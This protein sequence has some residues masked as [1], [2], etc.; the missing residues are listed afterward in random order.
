MVMG[1]RH[2]EFPI[3]GLQFHPESI[4]TPE[5]ELLIKNFMQLCV[6]TPSVSMDDGRHPAGKTPPHP[7]DK[8]PPHPTGKASPSSRG[9]TAGSREK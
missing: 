7:A 4:L 6:E 1:I 2:K 8:T 5:G 9:L 3:Y